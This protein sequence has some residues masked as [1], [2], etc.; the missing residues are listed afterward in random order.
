MKSGVTQGWLWDDF[1]CWWFRFR[2]WVWISF[3]KWTQLQN[4]W[5]DLMKSFVYIDPTHGASVYI[6]GETQIWFGSW[7]WIEISFKQG[8]NTRGIYRAKLPPN[9]QVLNMPGPALLALLLEPLPRVRKRMIWIIE[10]MVWMCVCWREKQHVMGK[11]FE[12]PIHTGVQPLLGA[13]ITV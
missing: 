9:I 12:W 11:C 3:Q 5:M 1:F 7:I 13:F 4:Y 6:L 8:R 2:F 10:N